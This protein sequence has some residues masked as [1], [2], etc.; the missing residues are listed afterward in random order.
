MQRVEAK[1]AKYI[2]LGRGGAWEGLCF[3]DGTLRLGYDDVPHDVA[4]APDRERIRQFFLDRGDPPQTAT[5]HAN[6]VFEFYHGG[7][8]TL[9]ITVADGFLWWSFAGPGVEYL[10]VEDD[11][12][13]PCGAPSTDGTI[14]ALAA[15]PCGFPSS[16]ASSPRW[17]AIR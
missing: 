14:G 17:S 2:K 11:G 8:E 5:N 3:E 6:Q 9:W 13:A 16:T 1:S 12:Q 4:L 7:P 10:G 15:S